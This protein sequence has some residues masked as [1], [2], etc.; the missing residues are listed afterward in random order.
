MHSYGGL[1]KILVFRLFS[2]PADLTCDAP[3]TKRWKR[4]IQPDCWRNSAR[5]PSVSFLETRNAQGGAF[6]VS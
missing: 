6:C 3:R 1:G 4:N 2:A 5:N